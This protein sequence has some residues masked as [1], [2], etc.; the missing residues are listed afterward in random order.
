MGGA[1]RGDARSVARHR[2]PVVDRRPDLAA[3]NRC[4]A[5]PLMPRNQQQ[6]A[7]ASIDRPF[8][9]EVDCAP[10]RVEVVAMEIEGAVWLNRARLEFAIP[11]SV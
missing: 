3:P 1:N 4:S 8:E 5:G 11:A 6:D 9:S 7:I 2:Q 10:R